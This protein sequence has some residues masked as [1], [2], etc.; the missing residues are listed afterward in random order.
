[1]KDEWC[2]FGFAQGRLFGPA[3]N[4]SLRESFCSAENDKVLLEM[5]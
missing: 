1:V 5:K 3:R 4:D 2:P